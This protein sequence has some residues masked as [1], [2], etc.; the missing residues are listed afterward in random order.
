VKEI[1]TELHVVARNF[2]VSSSFNT[3]GTNMRVFMQ[4]TK[5]IKSCHQVTTRLIGFDFERWFRF[6][7]IDFRQVLKERKF[8][9]LV[10]IFNSF[11]FTMLI[12][13]PT[14][15]SVVNTGDK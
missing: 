6:L 8:L 5:R 9:L 2:F 10:K 14:K 12:L 15:F 4:D 3:I 13:C 11:N 7:F 1:F